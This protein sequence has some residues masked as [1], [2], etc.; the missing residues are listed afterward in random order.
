MQF[1]ARKTVQM[2]NQLVRSEITA[3]LGFNDN[4]KTSLPD[5]SIG[6]GAFSFATSLL[7]KTYSDLYLTL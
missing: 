7:G 4:L 3:S 6:D 1:S 5:Q 2:C